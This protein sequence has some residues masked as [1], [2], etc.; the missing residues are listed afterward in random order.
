MLDIVVRSTRVVTPDGVV[1]LDIGIQGEV[2]SCLASHGTLEGRELH[3]LGDRIVVPGGIDPHVHTSQPIMPPGLEPAPGSAH[4]CTHGLYSSS[5]TDVSRSALF[6][7]TTTL[8]DFATW[9]QEGTLAE[10]LAVNEKKW[11]NLTYTDYSEHVMLLGDISDAILEEI[12]SIVRAGHPSFKMFTTNVFSGRA[13]R[14]VHYGHMLDVFKALAPVGGMA[15][16]HCEDD[17]L[18]VHAYDRHLAAG[19]VHFTKMPDVH[20]DLSEELAIR[21]VLRLGAAAGCRL[22]IMHVS[23]ELGVDAIREARAD[24]QDVHAETLHQY[25]LFSREHYHRQNGQ[26]YHSYPSLKEAHDCASLWQGLSDGTIETVATDGVVTTLEQ[27]LVGERID[28]VTGGSAGIEERM[29]VTYSGGLN[30]GMSLSQLAEATST[31]AARLLGMYPKKGVILPGSDADLVVLES[32]APA[33]LRAEDLHQTD[34][35]P[36]DGTEVRLWP[37]LTMLRGTVVV[38]DGKLLV[39]S[40]TGVRAPRSPMSV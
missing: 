15:A 23:C 5:P 1:A 30:R 29:A 35:S 21:Q 9:Q 12:P 13:G 19:D 17:D 36:W 38:S 24:G 14:R 2:I 28:D 6:G 7:G 40:P 18:V 10:A 39:D 31:N 16:L 20:T 32:R 33:P 3:D 37:V 27:K 34:Y 22:Y 25:A 4:N 8:V 11:A 26:I